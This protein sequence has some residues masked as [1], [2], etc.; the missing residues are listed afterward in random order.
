MSPPK[1]PKENQ[2]PVVNNIKF[3]Y[4][5][6]VKSSSAAIIKDAK[7]LPTFYPRKTTYSVKKTHFEVE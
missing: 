6:P 2:S 7:T 5:R 1:Y 3:D 4:S